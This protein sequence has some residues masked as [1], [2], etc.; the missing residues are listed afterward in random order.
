[1]AARIMKIHFT[2]LLLCV[3]LLQYVC[4]GQPG[5]NHARVGNAIVIADAHLHHGFSDDMDALEPHNFEYFF[6]RNVNI[7][8]YPLPVKKIKTDNLPQVI[9][10]E[11]YRLRLLSK[12]EGTFEIRDTSTNLDSTVT[13]SNKIQVFLSI[14]YFYGVFGGN[15]ETVKEYRKMG[16]RSITLINNDTDRFFENNRLT[17]F[18]KQTIH[19]MN[20]AEMI[21]DISHLSEAQMI[22]VINF[23]K[24]PVTASHSGVRHVANIKYNLSD[25]VLKLLKDKKGSVF[26]SFNK[27]GLYDGEEKI[28]DGIEQL[29]AHIDYLKKYLG[30]DY[31]GIGS[32]YQADGQY[33]PPALNKTGSYNLIVEGLTLKGYSVTEINKIMSRN[34][35]RI[36]GNRD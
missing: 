6:E 36:M 14:E 11:I 5:N 29:V 22:A 30:I 18:G 26:V 32:D 20:E 2:L 23:S 8:N 15:S 17:N 31:I 3:F 25:N 4:F 34:F 12:T 35:L 24:L 33:V 13:E 19:E 7:I 27:N 1:M 28:I 21:I 9:S 16:V 10:D